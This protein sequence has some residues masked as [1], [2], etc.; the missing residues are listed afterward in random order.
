[1]WSTLV[2]LQ[3]YTRLATL[4]LNTRLAH[5]LSPAYYAFANVHLHLIHATALFLPKEGLRR[6][7]QRL[8][9]GGNNEAL[10]HA[11]NLAWLAPLLADLY[12]FP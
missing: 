7:A 12:V 10:A 5:K 11:V 9:P 1:M 2:A 6:A 3:L 8:Y 4:A